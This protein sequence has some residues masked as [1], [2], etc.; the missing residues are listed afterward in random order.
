MLEY[1]LSRAISS[2]ANPKKAVIG[3]MSAL[4]VTGREASPMMM[5]QRQQP[6]QPWIFL[7]ELKENYAVRDIP[8]TTDKIDDDVSVLVVVH[9]QG[10]S[11]QALNLLSINFCFVAAKWW[12]C[13]T[14][15][16]LSKPKLPGHTEGPPDTIQHWTSC[17][18]LGESIFQ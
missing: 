15:T 16:L 3:V 6:S 9:P 17:C 4:P 13:S 10:I 7:T 8:M 2:V 5:Q 1:D 18:L 12:R 14:R 11:D